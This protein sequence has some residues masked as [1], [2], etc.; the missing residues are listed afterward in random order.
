MFKAL[1]TFAALAAPAALATAQ[2]AQTASP[3]P[4][5][6]DWVLE[7][8]PGGCIVH[9]ASPSGTVISIWAAAGQKDLSFLVQNR[10]WRT[11]EDGGRYDIQVSFDDQRAWPMQATAKTNLDSDGPG[12]TFAVSPSGAAGG[13]GFLE[14]FA[15]AGGM[16]IS[17][18]GTRVDSVSLTNSGTAM[19]AL[20]KC[21]KQVWTAGADAP[22]PNAGGGAVI[23]VS[24]DAKTI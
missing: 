8:A 9:A 15:S 17:R 1:L 4:R 7:V 13:A 21:L 2:P 11:L 16:H 6:G 23:T 18:N 19:T 24:D 3:A 14:Q 22:E 10:S 20:A 5:S 12:L